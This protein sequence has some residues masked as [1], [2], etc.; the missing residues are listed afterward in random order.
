[1]PD[2]H[3]TVDGDGNVVWQHWLKEP[4]ATR[5][6]VPVDDQTAERLAALRTGMIAAAIAY[7][8]ELDRLTWKEQTR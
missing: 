6:S 4:R 7:R 1:M 8:N 3:F 5:F 2:L